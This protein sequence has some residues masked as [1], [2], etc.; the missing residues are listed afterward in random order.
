MAR[1]TVEDCLESVDNRFELVMV[2]SKRA[3][4]L[5]TGGK[6]PLVQE[7]SDKPTVVAL[8]EIA[9]GLVTPDMLNREDELDAEEEL[10]EVMGAS[11]S[12]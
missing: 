5:A 7:E 10:A 4:Q 12:F 2:A 11:E 9:E 3:R 8:R 1:V 6:D